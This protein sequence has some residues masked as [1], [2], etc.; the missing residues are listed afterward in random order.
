MNDSQGKPAT[1][2]NAKFSP[3]PVYVATI[4]LSAWLVFGVQPLFTKMALPVLGGAPNVWNAAMVFFQAALLLGYLY[5]HVISTRLP[6]RLQ[7]VLHVGVLLAGLAF[8]PFAAPGGSAPPGEGAQGLWLIGVMATA[9]GLPFFALA[10][11]APLLQRWFSHSGHASAHDPYFLYAASNIGSMASL[12]LYPLVLEPMFGVRDQSR[13]WAYGYALLIALIACAALF[14]PKSK[15]NDAPAQVD[16][17]KKPLASSAVYWWIALAIPPSG[18]MLSVTTHLTMNVTPAP[19]LWIAPLALYL[20]SFV[21]AFGRRGDSWTRTS[22]TLFPVV[23]AIATIVFGFFP[24]EPPRSALLPL[25]LFFIIALAC[26]GELARRRPSSEHLTKFY[27]AMSLGGVVG[28]ALVALLAPLVFPDVYEYPLLVIAAAFVIAASNK[29]LVRPDVRLL[30]LLVIA[31]A[32]GVTLGSAPPNLAPV[33]IAVGTVIAFILSLAAIR[34]G[35]NAY[36]LAACVAALFANTLGVHKQMSRHEG[37][38]AFRARSFFGVS[39]V[40][41]V[42]TD[43][44]QAHS[45]LHGVTVHNIELRTEEAKSTPLAYYA[46]EGAFGQAISALRSETPAL[47]VA[48]IGLGAGALACH[49]VQGDEWTFFE[50]DA[51]VSRIARDDRYFSF[52]SKCAPDANVRIGDARIVLAREE[53]TAAKYDLIIVDAFSSDSVPAHLI[54]R[55]ALALYRS[56][57]APG[58]VVFMHTSNR[59]LDVNSVALRLAES[60][61]LGAR[62]IRFNPDPNGPYWRLVTPATAVV[63]GDAAVIERMAEGKTDWRIEKPSS[64]VNLWTDDYSNVV[65]AMAAVITGNTSAPR[66]GSERTQQ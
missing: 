7:P 66:K 6:L 9:I 28:G 53:A 10:A 41:R 59:Y 4:F 34:A 64:I 27:F 16:A 54:T 62:V 2:V 46:A 26:H 55:E 22:T 40:L 36:L 47:R 32:C 18:L 21:L 56:R 23:V 58:G 11:N 30:L 13:F 49:A 35:K 3:I 5:A 60:A 19:F 61:G 20:L 38:L 1:G 25:V 51:L 8:L 31:I 43:M 48:A 39:K 14:L 15:I 29:G 45:L 24:N 65:G 63:M 33:A 57:L 12:L 17:L 44:G 50:I 37:E 42:E 52:M